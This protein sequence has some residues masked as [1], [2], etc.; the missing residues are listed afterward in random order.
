V[1][2]LLFFSRNQNISV[3]KEN[4]NRRKPEQPKNIEKKQ[5]W[6][7]Y[8]SKFQKLKQKEN[9]LHNVILARIE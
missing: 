3:K 6:R 5:S 4:G 2:S 1:Q 7:T 8:T 9:N